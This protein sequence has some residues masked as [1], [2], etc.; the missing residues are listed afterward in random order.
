M[1]WLFARVPATGDPS[2]D[3]GFTLIELLVVI[4]LGTIVSV[5]VTSVLITG[6]RSQSEVSSHQTSLEQTRVAMQRITR[7]IRDATQIQSATSSALIFTEAT[8]SG[9]TT[10]TTITSVTS[11]S[12]TSLQ[13]HDSTTNATNTVLTSLAN[14]ATTPVFK[15][16]PV[17]GYVAA[18]PAAVDAYSCA[19]AG[20]TPTAY[21]PACIGSVT[22][23]LQQLIKGVSTTLPTNLL[24][25][26]ELRNQP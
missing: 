13:M 23:H 3:D 17:S 26:V 1:R 16:I 22:V 7:A 5:A 10:T 14:G 4:G 2:H 15:Y 25:T 19:I 9:G 20:T 12:A 8:N 21:A 18:N 6:L 11:G 24:D